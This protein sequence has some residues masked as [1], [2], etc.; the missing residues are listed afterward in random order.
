[1]AKTIVIFLL[2][3]PFAALPQPK[4]NPGETVK[5]LAA[6][7]GSYTAA[8]P[9]EK[10]YLQ[11]DKAFYAAGDTIY[12]KAYITI[13]PEHKLSALSGILHVD[14]ISPSDNIARSIKLPLTAGLAR[15]DF[16]LADTLAA[17]NY[18]IRA[19]TR[20]MRNTGED[21]FFERTIPVG[22]IT[23]P[24]RIAESGN[25]KQD[26]KNRPPLQKT[27][28]QFLP[29]GG[30]LVNGN[31]TTIAFKAIGPDGLGKAVKGIVTDES[32]NQVCRFASAHLGMG[33]FSLVPQS[34]EVYKAEVTFADST[35]ATF[36]LPKASDSGY[37]MSVNDTGA[38]TIR[39]R[40]TAARGGTVRRL[41][42]TAR[43][44]GIVYYTAENESD[45]RF[46]TAVIPKNK[47]PTGIVQFT[48]FSAQGEPLN[49]RLVFVNRHDELK[50]NLNAAKQ[51]HGPREKVEMSLEANNKDHQPVSGSFSVAVTDETKVPE[52]EDNENTILSDLLLTS[53]LKGYVEQPGYYFSHEDGKTRAALDLLM[54][55]QATAVTRGSRR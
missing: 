15:G 44:G 5:T 4:I 35:R 36:E 10:A 33:A 11:F 17:G 14:L 41:S 31:Y 52:D 47:F 48:L 7:L 1:M 9:V 12:F 18:R 25:F 27:D 38:D 42:L 6:K 53:D 23:A 39:I 51:S 49:E 40:V 32:G 21:C 8:H 16:A 43:S 22:A 13:G 34:G 50:L 20:W 24:V 37:T 30:S 3:L 29:E 55:T 45:K 26:K 46:F 2:L 28:V 19:Y 54:L